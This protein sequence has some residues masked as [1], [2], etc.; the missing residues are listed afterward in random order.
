MSDL[1]E[2]YIVGFPMRRP[3]CLIKSTKKLRGRKKLEIGNRGGSCAYLL[4]GSWKYGN[5]GGSCAYLL[6]GSSYKCELSFG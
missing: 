1:F 6:V 4:V 3:N 2:N 5:R